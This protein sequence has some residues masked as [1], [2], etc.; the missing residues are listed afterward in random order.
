MRTTLNW[1]VAACMLPVTLL[2]LAFSIN[3]YRVERALLVVKSTNSARVLMDAV[4][5]E[6]KKIDVALQ[7]L[8][9]S[10]ALTSRDYAAFHQQALGVVQ[11]G[12][13]E[14]IVL[15][16]GTGQQLM[17]TVV[18]P[19]Q[20]L[21]R[22]PD[23]ALV[24]TVNGV[25][26]SG[27]TAV[28]SLFLGP[29]L[30]KPLAMVTVPIRGPAVI[31]PGAA[32]AGPPFVLA[33]VKLPS[34]I[35]SILIA[36]KLPA[37]WTVSVID[38][39][40]ALVARSSGIDKLLG[41]KVVPS[42]AKLLQLGVDATSE[43]NGRDGK[44]VLLF[45]TPSQYSGWSVAVGI[46]LDSLNATLRGPFLWVLGLTLGSVLLSLAM[47]W[48]IGGRIAKAVSV[49]RK[50]AVELGSGRE[51]V[52]PPLSFKQANDVADA[53]SRASRTIV[54]TSTS[55]RESEGRM[56]S[57]LAS[58][59]DAI[60][61]FD[62][63]QTVLIFNEAAAEMFECSEADALG[64]LI[65]DF[66]PER[67][68]AR[69]HE[70][71]LMYRNS[72]TAFGKAIG[73]RRSGAEFPVEVSYSNVQQP[74]G[75]LHTLILRDITGRLANLEA[76]KRSNHDLQQFAYVASHDL[77][78]PLRSIS[79]FVQLLERKYA[80]NF[81]D[82]AQSLIKRTLAAT[83]RLEQLTDDLL[84]Y[85]RINSEMTPFVLVDLH[86]VATEVTQLLDAAIHEAGARV[87]I[88][89]LPTVLGARSQLIQLVL[90]LVG[91]ALKYRGTRA[92]VIRIS[93]IRRGND[94]DVSV[95]D[96]GIGIDPRHYERIF[97]V[98]KRLH[99]QNEYAGTGIGLA[100]CR[101]VVHQHG[102]KIWVESV[103]DQGSTFHFTLPAVHQEG[104]RL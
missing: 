95:E 72:G 5:D 63:Q 66:V 36:Q 60:I 26:G 9:T 79:G 12:F 53:I 27:K 18:A 38:R 43:G 2:S 85:A 41:T 47:A 61:T 32:P 83:G 96:N 101:R 89:K 42:V 28:S 34:R 82:G 86:S 51:V 14:S 8:A 94:W 59:K 74:S 78:T 24:K 64:S 93:A 104:A 62:D 92:P 3:H 65:T 102:G 80:Q 25:L 31:V 87:V 45:V 73:L 75:T 16:D 35:Q 13:S 44:P 19:S 29:A 55:L 48:L 100:V 71:I 39:S 17:N 52:V 20:P 6:F 99:G 88:E 7:A 15:V 68:R 50:S 76:L 22:I 21:P 97:E 91:N 49:L 98:F 33:G 84:A 81:E 69:H 58:A 30:K 37:D 1:L 90:N 23:E 67:F 54:N 103:P 10:P 40:G 46:P 77:K 11:R 56:R 57:I 70:Y 4:D